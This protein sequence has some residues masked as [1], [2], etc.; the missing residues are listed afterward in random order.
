MCTNPWKSFN[1]TK[2]P[3]ILSTEIKAFNDANNKVG[4]DRKLRDD[5]LPE[6]FIGC[7]KA[8]IYFLLANPGFERGIDND[9]MLKQPAYQKAVMDNLNQNCDVFFPFYYFD[10]VFETY[11]NGGHKWWR[12]KLKTFV[13]DMV[14]CGNLEKEEVSEKLPRKIFALEL[15]GYHSERFN[16]H[17]IDKNLPSLQYAICLV[18]EAIKENK[19]VFVLRRKNLWIDLVPELLCYKHCY[20]A[21]SSRKISITRRNLSPAAIEDAKRHF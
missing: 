17:F 3:F 10:P 13:N 9:S 19:T 12:P 8:P 11:E 21:V 20:F 6:P 16:E 15:Y 1:Q 7:H 5:C 2:S 14:E 18:R 4:N